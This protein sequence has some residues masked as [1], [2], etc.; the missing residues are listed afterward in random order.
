MSGIQREW[1]LKNLVG[2]KKNKLVFIPILKTASIFYSSLFEKNNFQQVSGNDIDWTSDDVYGFLMNPVQRYLKGLT[3]DANMVHVYGTNLKKIIFE[4]LNYKQLHLCLL[5]VHSLPL[6]LQ[7]GEYIYKIKWLPIDNQF[8][9]PNTFIDN[10]CKINNIEINW[11]NHNS[12]I[13]TSDRQSIELFEQLKQAW[14]DGNSHFWQVYGEDLDLY[15]SVI[16][17]LPLIAPVKKIKF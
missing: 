16:S 2:Y 17:M 5:T 3:E 8:F 9:D 7:L 4:I 1:I 15:A 12:K 6:S 14:S 13:H 11:S 10:L